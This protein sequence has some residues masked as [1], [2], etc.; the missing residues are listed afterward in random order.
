MSDFQFLAKLYGVR[1]SYPITPEDGT[2]IGGNTTCFMVRSPEHVVIFDAGSGIIR[3]GQEL[4]PEIIEHNKKNNKP[5]HI[6][7]IF[8]HTHSDHLIGFPFFTPIYMPNVHIHFFGPATLGMDFKEILSMQVLPQFFPVSMDE[9]RC[10]KSFHNINEN[11]FIYFNSGEPVPQVGYLNETEAAFSSFSIY[12]MKYYLHPKDGSYI[13]RVEKDD[14]KLVF[15]TDVEE[16]VGGD[17]RLINFSKEADI[18]IHDAQYTDDQ[19]KQFAGYGHS[20]LSMACDAA[21]QA[22]VKKLV[23]FHHNPGNSDSLLR[24]MEKTAQGLFPNTELGTEKWEW[25]L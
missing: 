8:T 2:K 19:Y 11:M 23:L 13:Y 9:F 14:K 7:I 20:S 6:T 12:P 22:N 15:A 5:F 24:E 10:G 1:G 18:L 17:Q 21:K 4:I 3:L 16:C 25:K